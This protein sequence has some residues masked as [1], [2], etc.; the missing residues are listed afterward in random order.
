VANLYAAESWHAGMPVGSYS[1]LR[2]GKVYGLGV[3]MLL[4]SFKPK[5]AF[6]DVNFA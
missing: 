2:I 3:C 5:A 1:I 6:S 4:L